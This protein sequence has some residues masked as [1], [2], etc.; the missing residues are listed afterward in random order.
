[1]N[2]W[3]VMLLGTFCCIVID[4]NDVVIVLFAALNLFCNMLFMSEIRNTIVMC[5][6]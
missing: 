5:N 1:M 6:V 2:F 3:D 4:S